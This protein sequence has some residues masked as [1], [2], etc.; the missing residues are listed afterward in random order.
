MNTFKNTIPK[1]GLV[2]LIITAAYGCGGG[3]GNGGTTTPPVAQ[4]LTGTAAAGAPIIGTVTIKDSS[5]P[6]K[7]KF[8]TIA[9]DGKYTIDVTGLTA[10]FML[11]ADGT[12]GGRSYSIYSAAASADVGGTVNI[13]PLTDL[14]VANIAGQIAGNYY[15]SGNF[16]LL[17]PAALNA[18]EAAL[19]ARLQ[20][21]LSAIGLADTID[22]LRASF[23]TDHTGVDA[24]LDILRVTVDPA[25]ALATVTNVITNQ[26]IIDDLASQTDVTQLTDTT[27]VATGL[28]DFQQIVAK[29]DAFSNLFATSLPA[30]SNATLNALFDG[31]SF[32][33]DGQSLTAFLSD[34]T[35]DPSLIGIKFT[36]VALVSLTPGSAPT[37]A[38]VRFTVIQGGSSHETLEFKANKVSG[39]WLIAGNQRIAGG[40]VL[41]FA[42]QDHLGAI[43][44]GLVADGFR[45]DGGLG[46]DYAIVKGKALPTAIVGTGGTSGGLLLVNYTSN[47]SFGVAQPPYS[48]IT[49]PRLHSNGHNQHPLADADINTIADNEVYTHEFWE[50]NS[51]PSN[52]ADDV[53]LATYTDVLGKRPYLNSEL[54]AAS[55]AT[56][57]STAAAIQSAALNGGGLAVTWTLPAGLQSEEVHFFRSYNSGSSDSIDANVASTA[58]SATLTIAAPTGMVAGSGINLYVNDVFGRELRSTQNGQ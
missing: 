8:V 23:S 38:Q 56:I 49:T 51:T 4:T 28:T 16:S 20:P 58:T 7:D 6:A 40:V 34:I 11:R 42:R 50:D 29:F 14:I 52:L 12:V 21:I 41:S 25:T 9:A 32:L 47:N 37:T 24:A 33:F 27:G 45:D 44:T 13:T 36:N 10:P 39:V 5:S 57:T 1:L 30:S 48:G 15:N 26:Q 55:F 35:S 46:I 43:D 54:S 3:G 19:Q 22:L 2:L 17:T 18:A 53:L 31:P